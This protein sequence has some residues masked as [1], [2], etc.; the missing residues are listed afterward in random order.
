MEILLPD[1][2]QSINQDNNEKS[3]EPQEEE[4]ETEND[5]LADVYNALVEALNNESNVHLP[6]YLL[7]I[8]DSDLIQAANVYDF[9]A[10]EMYEDMIKWLLINI[11]STVEL[12]KK[13]LLK[14]RAGAVSTTTE[15]RLVWITMLRRPN[16]TTRKEIF[17][18]TRKF[19][20]SLEDIIS[21]DKRSHILKVHIEG[22]DTN[23]NENGDLTDVGLVKYWRS[24]DAEMAD[25]DHGKIELRP[26]SHTKVVK[27]SK[28]PRKNSRY[29]W[30]KPNINAR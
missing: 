16:N 4:N 20:S 14:R 23:F 8:L 12:R 17:A 28:P 13:Q 24:I 18:L 27:I 26:A 9:G 11:S 5:F 21:K 3:K 22:N 30:S 19:N 15:P 2:E 7:I 25:F 1:T 10:M 6:R 29:R